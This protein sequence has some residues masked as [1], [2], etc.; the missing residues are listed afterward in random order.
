MVARLVLLLLAWFS[1]SVPQKGFFSGCKAKLM[2]RDFFGAF[3]VGIFRSVEGLV[4]EVGVFGVL[5]QGADCF[6]V[7]ALSFSGL[8]NGRVK[9]D[10]K[11]RVLMGVEVRRLSG[12][13]E[14]FPSLLARL[15]LATGEDFPLTE[16][17]L[18]STGDI[19]PDSLSEVLLLAGEMVLMG[20]RSS[21]SCCGV[22]RATGRTLPLRPCVTRRT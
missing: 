14:I 17:A 5:K 12:T 19:V 8:F 4:R 7:R 21:S 6:L 2:D 13:G 22:G 10:F 11:A 18:L 15:I 9:A 16:E 1:L 20:E 3:K